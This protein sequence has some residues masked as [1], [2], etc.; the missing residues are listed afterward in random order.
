MATKP[1]TSPRLWGTN[2][3]Y[4]TGPFIGQPGKVD[5]GVGIAAEGHRPGAA[6]PTPAEYENYQQNR[7]TDWITNWVR[8][9]T[10]NPDATA[11]LV[12]TDSTGRAGL[13]G[14]DVVDDVDEIAVNVTGVGT[15][16]PTVLATCTTGA[17]VFQADIG[18]STGT[19]FAGTTNA[20][21]GVVFSAGMF[22]TNS[23][24]AGLRVV[25]DLACGSPAI[26]VEYNGVGRGVRISNTGPNVQAVLIDSNASTTAVGLEVQVGGASAAIQARS[27]PL[28]GPAVR[29]FLVNPSG[30]A[31]HGTAGGTSGA[32]ARAG[33]FAAT[34]AGTGVEASAV[35]NVAQNAALRLTMQAGVFPGSELAFTGRGGD[36]TTTSG[37]RLNYNTVTGTL[38]LSDPAAAEQKD[39][40]ASRG[41]A[42]LGCGANNSATITNNN[43]AVFTTCATLNLV[44]MNAPRRAGV[45]VVL[46]FTCS[47]GRTTFANST[48]VLDLQLTDVTAG[49]VILQRSGAGQLIGSGYLL[50]YNNTGWQRNISLDFEY[51]IPLAGDRT[52]TMG[53]RTNTTDG[54]IIRDPVLVPLGSYT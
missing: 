6:F 40:W 38:T 49:A 48:G 18:N 25:T 9:G 10:F 50:T 32:A 15:V 34:A 44:N 2:A 14:L 47:V 37:G 45:K 30:A 41:G 29:A 22:G 42:T 53:F 26:E 12:E 46:R 28:A 17:S 51:T 3:L 4:T 5:P 20:Q 36:S 33:L 23:G 7:T 24:G 11:H 1:L 19:G 16:V 39:L 13:H 31:V 8:L 27:G 21:P 54:V 43:A 35:G 52:F